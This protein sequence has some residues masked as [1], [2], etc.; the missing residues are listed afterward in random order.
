M[1][2]SG[3]TYIRD[4]KFEQAR[5]EI[6]DPN[7]YNSSGDQQF[8]GWEIDNCIFDMGDDTATSADTGL[9]KIAL[10]I[11]E[12]SDIVNEKG[13][14]TISKCKFLRGKIKTGPFSGPSVS[15]MNNIN[16]FGCSMYGESDDGMLL[17]DIFS[18]D[19]SD[20]PE[21]HNISFIGNQHFG[22]QYT[23]LSG[24]GPD[25]I[26]GS[27]AE[28][29]GERFSRDINVG[30]NAYVKGSLDAEVSVSTES[31]EYRTSKIFKQVITF[32][33]YSTFNYGGGNGHLSGAY[34][35][36]ATIGSVNWAVAIIPT[37][38]SAHFKINPPDGSTIK[39]IYFGV[40]RGATSS[41]H[42][43][44]TMEVFRSALDGTGGSSVYGAN[45]VT[46]TEQAG[47]QNPAIATYS[48]VNLLTDSDN[49]LYHIK[50]EH[51]FSGNA[52]VYW[53]K[54]EY[55]FTKIEKILG[56]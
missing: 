22:N 2:T 45:T 24:N 50:L 16:I 54:I 33:E 43:N 4:I 53:I 5:I 14:V 52:K 35:G 32:E 39:N 10:L 1:P 18:L 31:F 41:V 26:N 9:A 8:Y 19:S 29:W 27:A 3:F 23:L 49:Y 51:N 46:S 34:I 21:E 56:V 20:R 28:R 15:R 38:D 11:G 40:V 47:G 12:E 7:I 25:M 55:E 6:L 48:N 13:N 36:A 17:G 30:A 44:W 42:Y 37:S